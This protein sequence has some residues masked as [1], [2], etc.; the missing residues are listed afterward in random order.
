MRRM[1]Y[2]DNFLAEFDWFEFKLFP[3]LNWLPYQ[4]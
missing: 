1:K 4:D 2:L 3:L